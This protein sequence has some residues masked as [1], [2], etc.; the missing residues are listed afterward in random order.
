ME[1]RMAARALFIHDGKLLAIKH[2]PYLGKPVN[3]WCT[4]GGGVDPNESLEAAVIR[5]VIEETGITPKIG[6]LLYVQQYVQK[7]RE[8]IEFFFLIENSEDYLNVDLTK[9]THGSQ[10]IEEIAYINPSDSKY[11][12][13]PD[14]LREIDLNLLPESTKI[15]NYLPEN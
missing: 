15:F 14:F 1:R 13:L 9:S 3:Y 11:G 4:I 10:E 2:T 7:E 8:H 6:R 12:L 5:E